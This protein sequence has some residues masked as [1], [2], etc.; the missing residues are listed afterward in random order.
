MYFHRNVLEHEMCIIIV[1]VFTLS[2]S[3][4]GNIHREDADFLSGKGINALELTLNEHFHSFLPF[5]SLLEKK[6]T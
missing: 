1:I 4:P 3:G 6:L 2:S 5:L